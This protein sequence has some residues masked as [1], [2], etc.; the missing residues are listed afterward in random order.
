MRT[1][2]LLPALLI[3]VALV[4]S[5][6]HAQH[7]WSAPNAFGGQNWHSGSAQGSSTPNVFGG[8]NF[9]FGNGRTGYSTPNVFGG[10]NYNWSFANIKLGL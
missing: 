3:I 2:Y 4:A 7:G 6:A 8:Q 9:N 10:R 1:H 5:S